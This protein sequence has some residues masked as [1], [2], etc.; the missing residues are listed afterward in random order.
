MFPKIYQFDGEFERT[1]EPR[2]Q[3]YR[4]RERHLHKYAS[5]TALDYAGT[6]LP[7]PGRTIVM[8]LA[9]SAGEFYGPNRN[10]DAW[11]ERPLKIG[12]TWAVAPGETLPDHHQTFENHATVYK[13][14]I[15]KDPTNNYG[16]VLKSFYNWKM[17][18]VELFLSVD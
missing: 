2:C 16:D 11:S 17:H 8:V 6:I 18:R 12:N 13:H 10:G 14:H 9:M 3:I 7:V 5:D 15:N 1:G 4:P